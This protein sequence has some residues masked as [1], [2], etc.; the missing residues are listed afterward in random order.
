MEFDK[1]GK[2]EITVG[3]A[4]DK[5]AAENNYLILVKTIDNTGNEAVYASN[6]IVVDVT[7]PKVECTFDTS[8]DGGYV[9]EKMEFCVIKEMLNTSLRLKIQKN[10][11]QVFRNWK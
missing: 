9:S 5:E 1:N 4:K 3:K 8:K 11:S 6:G 7:S 10:I 2:D